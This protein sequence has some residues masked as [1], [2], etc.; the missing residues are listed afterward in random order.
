MTSRIKLTNVEPNKEIENLFLKG[1]KRSMHI[2]KSKEEVLNIYDYLE[3][4][5]I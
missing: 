4:E 3:I 5:K 1:I 2:Q